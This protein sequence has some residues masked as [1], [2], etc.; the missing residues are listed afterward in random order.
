MG[1]GQTVK[2]LGGG[3][4]ALGVRVDKPAAA[5]P[6]NA[7]DALFVVSYGKILLT[8]I[9]GQVTGVL[10][11]GATNARLVHTPAT[12]QTNLCG[13]L[14]VT[15]DPVDTM[16]SITGTVANA[17]LEDAGGGVDA[18]TMP[19]LLILQPGTISLIT[20]QAGATGSIKWVLHYVALDKY[21]VVRPAA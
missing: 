6:Q 2:E 19:I 1:L 9:M 21:A 12:G 10:G 17:M 18:A 15:T 13:D 8:S 5:V 7:L 3:L 4:A 11:G 20:D 16:Y 14:V